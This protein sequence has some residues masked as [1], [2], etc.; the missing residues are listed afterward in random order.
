MWGGVLISDAAISALKPGSYI[1][2]S[3][4]VEL[5]VLKTYESTTREIALANPN[6]RAVYNSNGKF[7]LVKSD[8]AP[9]GRSEYVLVP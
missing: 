2:G 9:D 8:K 3:T 7:Y 1:C 4:V 6:G 5:S